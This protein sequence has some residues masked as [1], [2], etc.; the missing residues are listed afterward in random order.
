MSS[1]AGIGIVVL[2]VGTIIALLLS[3]S[4]LITQVYAKNYLSSKS[5]DEAYECG[6]EGTSGQSSR[7]SSGYYLTAILFVLFDIEI[8]FLYPWAI[9][10]RKFINLN[11]GTPYFIAF[12]IFLALF[13]VGLFWEI[14]VKALNWK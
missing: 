2:I 1:L 13:V 3:I 9:A 12:I 8:I 4:H 5:K 10:Y 11:E 14:R 7:I 6:V